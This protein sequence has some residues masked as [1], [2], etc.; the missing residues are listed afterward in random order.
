MRTG[1]ARVMAAAT[2]RAAATGWAM[3]IATER[4]MAMARRSLT[5]RPKERPSG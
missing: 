4:T 1:R 5:E 3:P 2:V